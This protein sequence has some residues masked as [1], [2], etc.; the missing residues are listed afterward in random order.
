MKEYKKNIEKRAKCRERITTKI[1]LYR[2]RE[3]LIRERTK[4]YYRN[5]ANYKE[6]EDINKEYFLVRGE[7][8][9]Q[10]QRMVIYENGMFDFY[11]FM[12]PDYRKKTLKKVTIHG[13]FRD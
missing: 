2:I 11:K 5:N 13:R 10:I 1:L 6:I 8:F 12:V 7:D 4:G 9:I 3:I